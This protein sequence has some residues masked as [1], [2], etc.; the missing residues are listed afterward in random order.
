MSY[1]IIRKEWKQQN[2]VNYY[3][4]SFNYYKSSLVEN[5]NSHCCS[6]SEIW[7]IY[8]IRRKAVE[9]F[10]GCGMTELER[11]LESVNRLML[12]VQFPFCR[13]VNCKI[14]ENCVNNYQSKATRDTL[15]HKKLDLLLNATKETDPMDK[16]GHQNKRLYEDLFGFMLDDLTE[17]LRR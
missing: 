5:G 16:Y 2:F 4:N 7:Q 13:Q 17:S 8:K 6:Y 3:C 1:K 10:Y 9:N 15:G 12:L 14:P 11:L